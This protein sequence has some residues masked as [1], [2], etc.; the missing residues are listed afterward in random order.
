VD[1]VIDAVTAA[2]LGVFDSRVVAIAV[3]GS[4]VTGDLFPRLSDVDFVVVLDSPLRLHDSEALAARIDQIDIHPFAYVQCTYHET[5]APMPSVV[6]GAF[7][8]LHG[9]LNDGFLHT[10][11]SL[12]STGT[13]WMGDLPRIVDQDMRDWSVAVDRRPRQLRLILTRVK[14]TVRAHLVTLGDDPIA[15]YRHAWP[16]LTDR[17]RAY[18]PPLATDCSSLLGQLRGSDP[19]LLA[20]GAQALRLLARFAS[21]DRSSDEHQD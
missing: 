2:Y 5:G 1:A 7:S 14:P 17:L 10:E 19:D 16:V 9:D 11:G 8:R 3:H 21:S 18:D 15:T 13:N 4:A 6:P 20:V 12:R